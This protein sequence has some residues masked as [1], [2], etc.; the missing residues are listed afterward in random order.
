MISMDTL[1]YPPLVVPSKDELRFAKP[2]VIDFEWLKQASESSKKDIFKTLED[3]APTGLLHLVN[4]GLDPSLFQT[5][6]GVTYTYMMTASMEEKDAASAVKG[7]GSFEGY[8]PRTENEKQQGV[9]PVIEEWNYD[10][11]SSGT[12][13]RPNVIKENEESIRKIFD[14][15]HK[16]LT[17]RLL[18][19]INDFCELPAGSLRTAHTESSEVA[20]LLL[21]RT[22]IRASFVVSFGLQRRSFSCTHAQSD[23]DIF[24]LLDPKW[25]NDSGRKRAAYAGHT[26]IG[27]ITYL[28]ANPV[29]SLQVYGPNGWEYVAYIPNSLVINMGDAMQ[30]LTQGRMNATLH[31]V[32]KPTTDQEEAVRTALV[33]FVHPNHPDMSS[34][35]QYFQQLRAK[36][37]A[38]TVAAPGSPID[39]VGLNRVISALSA[40][41]ED[42][43][44]SPV[45]SA[46]WAASK[47]GEFV[48]SPREFCINFENLVV[49]SVPNVA[50]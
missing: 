16:E 2:H 38:T 23:T 34:S 41:R 27:S 28:Y 44:L 18:D 50:Y 17:P 45:N 5:L 43:Y 29:A 36:H 1:M 21:Y 6:R 7:T 9:L 24:G 49:T 15:Y 25:Y 48:R 46:A 13:D 22:F 31:R 37:T 26:D 12:I 20:H 14:F 40:M 30:F 39:G 47:R 33:Y 11:K 10:Y 42:V 4:H 32:I 8:K 3:A 19:A 35:L